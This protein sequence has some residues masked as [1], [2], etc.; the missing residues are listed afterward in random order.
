MALNPMVKLILTAL[1]VTAVIFLQIFSWVIHN[2]KGVRAGRHNP[3]LLF[4]LP[5]LLCTFLPFLL[6]RCCGE[7]DSLLS[8]GNRGRHC[9]CFFFAL[10]LSLSRTCT[11][12][13]CPIH[14]RYTPRAR[15]RTA[16]L[17]SFLYVRAGAEFWAAFFFCSSIALPIVMI[18]T[19][20][21]G[22]VNFVLAE[23]AIALAVAYVGFLSFLQARE[24]ADAFHSW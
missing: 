12:A 14:F 19:E 22:I 18:T 11:H 6:M 17:L 23:G 10:R 5:L 1:V 16:S 8:S 4:V 3:L 13:H 9:A 24:E 21:I 15:S 2:E 7:S 20:A